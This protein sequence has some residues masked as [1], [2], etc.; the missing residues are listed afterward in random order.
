MRFNYFTILVLIN[1]LVL[2]PEWPNIVKPT[3]F[4]L[5]ETKLKLLTSLQ[6]LMPQNIP[7]YNVSISSFS[8][9]DSINNNGPQQN[10]IDL[11][12]DNSDTS[13]MFI[14]RELIN[15]TMFKTLGLAN[16]F[17]NW[18]G[19]G[20]NSNGKTSSDLLSKSRWLN[21]TAFDQLLIPESFKTFFIFNTL[22]TTTST[23]TPT[24]ISPS[25][26]STF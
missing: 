21:L 13:L 15:P 18:H 2:P 23:S 11:Q 26:T 19:F 22:G 6:S 9:I 25:S 1:A 10:H 16:L 4:S 17:S 3:L 14:P 12:T 5:K 24:M 20:D 8:A 7:D